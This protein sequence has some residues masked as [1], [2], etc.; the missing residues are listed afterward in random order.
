MKTFKLFTYRVLC[1]L[2]VVSFL[3]IGSCKKKATDPDYCGTSWASQVTS[4]SN[5]LSTAIQTYATN[6]TPANCTALKTAYQNYLNALEPFVDCASWT[7]QQSNELQSAIDE[8][9]QQINTLCQ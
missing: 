9:Q 6:Q 5:A 8:A 7:A 4:Q 3:G 2:I 1:I